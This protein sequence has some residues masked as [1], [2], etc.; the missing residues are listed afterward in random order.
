MNITITKE[1]VEFL[2]EEEF[3]NDSESMDEDWETLLGEFRPGG[4][5]ATFSRYVDA[6]IFYKV[7]GGIGLFA[8]ELDDSEGPEVVDYYVLYTDAQ[9]EAEAMAEE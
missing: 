2:T 9:K 5:I 1:E 8:C 7:Y 4:I 6:L 3:L